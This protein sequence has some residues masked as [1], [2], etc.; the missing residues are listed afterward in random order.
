M[1]GM[2]SIVTRATL[3]SLEL[4]HIL[5][6]SSKL[7]LP[8]TETFLNKQYIS[9][10]PIAVYSVSQQPF[11]DELEARI[12]STLTQINTAYYECLSSETLKLCYI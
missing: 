7:D 11:I 9:H 4:R 1:R 6:T 12:V 2:L 3:R 5:K 10:D 8:S